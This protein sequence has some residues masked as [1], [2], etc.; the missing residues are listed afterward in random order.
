MLDSASYIECPST[1]DSGRLGYSCNSVLSDDCSD[2]VRSLALSHIL[3]AS[4]SVFPDSFFCLRLILSSSWNASAF[5]LSLVRVDCLA[6]CPS[7]VT[8]THQISPRL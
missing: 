5:F 2:A 3:N 6:L 4:V 8:Y 7:T 1:C